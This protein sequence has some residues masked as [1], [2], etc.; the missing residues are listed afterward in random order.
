[1][2]TVEGDAC[3]HDIGIWDFTLD[4]GVFVGWCSHDA[5][6]NDCSPFRLIN[7]ARD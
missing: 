3:M 6:S 7:L 1:M 5:H 4:T 2:R